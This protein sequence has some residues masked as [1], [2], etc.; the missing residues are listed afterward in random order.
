MV[1]AE[2][3]KTESATL[4]PENKEAQKEND[5]ERKKE[6]RVSLDAQ[7]RAIIKRKTDTDTKTRYIEGL[8]A[9]QHAIFNKKMHNHMSK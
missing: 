3:E 8:N 9:Q 7:T 1:D 6:E 2:R 5:A 4:S